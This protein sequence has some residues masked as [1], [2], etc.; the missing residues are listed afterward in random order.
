MSES[1]A[2]DRRSDG[3]SSHAEESDLGAAV[4]EFVAWAERENLAGEAVDLPAPEVLGAVGPG[5]LLDDFE[6]GRRLGAGGMGVVFEARQRSVA[7]RRV[8]VKVLRN[9]FASRRME[10]RFRREIDAISTLDHPGIVPIVAAGVAAGLPYYAMR[11]VE[12]VSAARIVRRLKERARLPPSMDDVRRLVAPA[13]GDEGGHED[14][15]SSGSGWDDD[16]DAPWSDSYPHWVARLGMLAAES[17]QHAHERQVVHRDVKPANVVVTPRG[18][19]VLLDFGLADRGGEGAL[20]RTGDFL[21][22]LSYASPEQARGEELDHRSDVYSLGATL[23]ELLALR[24]PFEAGSRPE[25]LRRI[26]EERVR[27]LASWV[28]R[29]LRTIVLHALEKAPERRY[30][31]AA[32]MASDLRAFLAG[33]P[34]EAHPPGLLDRCATGIRRHPLRAGL[35]VLAVALLVLGV[36]RAG[37]H[38]SAAHLV[39]RADAILELGLQRRAELRRLRDRPDTYADWRRAGTYVQPPPGHRQALADLA[40]EVERAF[41]GA[42]SSYLEAFEHVGD[43]ERARRGLVRLHARELEAALEDHLDVLDPARVELLASELR[44]RG[45]GAHAHLLDA[46]GSFTLATYPPGARVTVFA[47]AAEEGD[48]ALIDDTAPLE[49][50]GVPEGSYRAEIRSPGFAPTTYPFLVRRRACAELGSDVPPSAHRVELLPAAAVPA[51]MVHVPGGWTLCRDEPPRWEEVEGFLIARHEVTF[52]DWLAMRRHA[53][54]PPPRDAYEPDLLL[55]APPVAPDAS[56]WTVAAGVEERW[57]VVGLA[58]SDMGDYINALQRLR[59]PEPGWYFSLPTRSEWLRAARGADARTWPWGEDFDWQ[60]CAGYPSHRR[61][62]DVD[63][64]PVGSHPGDRSPFGVEDLA[65]SVTEATMSPFPA[66]RGDFLFCGGSCRDTL[67]ERMSVLAFRSLINQPRPDAGFRLVQRRLPVW[68]RGDPAGPAVFRDDFERPDGDLAGTGWVVTAN[69]PLSPRI[70]PNK[71]T[72][73]RIEDGRLVLE[74]GHGHHSEHEIAWHRVA[75]TEAGFTARLVARAA[76]RDHLSQRAF[77]IDLVSGL[78]PDADQVRLKLRMSGGLQ[79]G[80]PGRAVT[81]PYPPPD[82]GFLVFELG[83]RPERL[84]GRV[85]RVEEERPDEPQLVLEDP[86]LR[87]PL[88]FLQLMAHNLAGVRMEV[89]S[90]EV[91]PAELR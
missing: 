76:G 9:L 52:A 47:A 91:V 39:E 40:A 66:V 16:A 1:G 46:T 84:E 17:L 19:P 54:L 72:P 90:V 11:Y 81:A 70:D 26:E 79:L 18:R 48:A 63:P 23:Y 62:E 55:V 53:D 20:T 51:G 13:A 28:P 37:A 25:L 35:A 30:P 89:E 73:G 71:S 27:E 15:K 12:G 5:S 8:A 14:S 36:D 61:P 69:L 57:P 38:R 21:G 64:F 34:I 78:L 59:P 41:R 4:D 83:V 43:H 77:G 22:T 82:D 29:D 24:C 68:A 67:P 49:L 80:R 32:A 88:R 74:G 87:A 42:R 86:E 56:A 75:V 31:S 50:A 33:R 6:L 3:A 65:G 45:Q 58:R 85:W 60:R 2:A 7:G 44:R 10:A